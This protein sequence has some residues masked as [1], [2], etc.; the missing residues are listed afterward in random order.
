MPNRNGQGPD[1]AGPQ[2]G[3]RRG[4]CRVNTSESVQQ[5]LPQN[6]GTG[7]VCR[8]PRGC[9]TGKQGGGGRGAGMG[10]RGGARQS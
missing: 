9:G 7:Q 4:L 6:Q 10:R 3:R 2:T 1:D 8:G 5:E